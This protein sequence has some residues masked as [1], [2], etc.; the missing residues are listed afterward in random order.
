MMQDGFL[1]RNVFCW[2]FAV[3]D[4]NF[5]SYSLVFFIGI[6]EIDKFSSSLKRNSLDKCRAIH[7]PLFRKFQM[8][9]D[10]SNRNI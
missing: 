5:H 9:Y 1:I 2:L 6:P 8:V 3:F 4:V 7:N 10:G